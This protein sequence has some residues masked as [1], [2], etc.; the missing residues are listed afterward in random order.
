MIYVDVFTRTLTGIKIIRAK[1]KD[2]TVQGNI[3]SV[4]TCVDEFIC[5]VCYSVIVE[6]LNKWMQLLL[7]RCLEDMFLSQPSVW[8]IAYLFEIRIECTC[9][10]FVHSSFDVQVE[11]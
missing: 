1:I 11:N 3:R 7:R 4:K 8:Y 5:I 10:A 2:S 9:D 6:E